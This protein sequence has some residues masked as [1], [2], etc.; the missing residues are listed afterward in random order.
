MSIFNP[1]A[2]EARALRDKEGIGMMEAKRRLK[3]ENMLRFLN[4]YVEVGAVKAILE[5]LI[6]DY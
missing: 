6:E 4:T 3:K 1:S 2:I 5:E